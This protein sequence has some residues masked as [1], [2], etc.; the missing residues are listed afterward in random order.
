MPEI[1]RESFAVKPSL[2]RETPK[3]AGRESW[4][5]GAVVAVVVVVSL[6]VVV[7]ELVKVVGVVFAVVVVVDLVAV[8]HLRLSVS[9]NFF[10]LLLLQLLLL[11]RLFP[12]F[13]SGP[14][15]PRESP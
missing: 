15:S 11:L 13:S 2:Y 1:W 7:V 6:G 5:V 12:D 3:V 9:R 14:R 4:V 10:F 8:F